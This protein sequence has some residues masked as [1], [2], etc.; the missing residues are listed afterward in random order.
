[1]ITEPPLISAI[2]PV[3]NGA[4][5]VAAA[6]ESALGQTHAPLEIIVVDDG[7]TDASARIVQGFG[8]RL[9]YTYQPNRGP[10]AARNRGLQ[11]AHGAI[12]AFLDADDLWPAGKLAHQSRRLAADATLEVVLGH[13]QFVEQADEKGEA[14][15]LIN[16]PYPQYLLGSAL[17][18]R[19][20]FI[21]VGE[22]DETLRYCDD[23]DWFLRAQDL[24]VSMQMD[25]EVALYYRRH[26]N[27]LTRS[28]QSRRELLKLL[29]KGLAR[30]RSQGGERFALPEWFD[31]ARRTN[32]NG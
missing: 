7:S 21:R 11:S 14:L 4:A 9:T 15:T 31:S 20:A 26:R 17:F 25:Q 18:R 29:Q 22:F 8:D 28:P 32:A 10:A 5:F 16:E 19:S 2:M 12:I 1:M 3:Y 13:T 30:R 6:I 27:N 24:Q 23:W